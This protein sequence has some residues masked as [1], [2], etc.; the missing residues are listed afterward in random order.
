M[1]IVFVAFN[2]SFLMSFSKTL[3]SPQ[4]SKS[5]QIYFASR[6][7]LILVIGIFSNAI[8]WWFLAVNKAGGSINVVLTI[9]F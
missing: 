3:N 4:A 8:T 7:Y 6:C 5:L 2:V 1:S 9:S